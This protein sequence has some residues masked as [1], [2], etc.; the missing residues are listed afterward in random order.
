MKNLWKLFAVSAFALVPVTA[1]AA[2]TITDD[3]VCTA[4]DTNAMTECLENSATK[5]LKLTGSTY[6]FYSGKTANLEEISADATATINVYGNVTV[7]KINNADIT[8]NIEKGGKLTLTEASTVAAI[9]A[10]GKTDGATLIAK[11]LTA[12]VT[13][14]EKATATI[15]GTLTG[16]LTASKE[17]KVT[18]TATG[19]KAVF[20]DVTVNTKANVTV[21]ASKVGIAGDVTLATA[22]SDEEATLTVKASTVRNAIEGAVTTNG[23]STL[24]VTSGEVAGVITMNDKSAFNAT[25]SKVTPAATSDIKGGTMIAKEI[26]GTNLKISGVDA[27]VKYVSGSVTEANFSAGTLVTTSKNDV[28]GLDEKIV[29][30]KGVAEITI[31][32]GEVYDVKNVDT[33]GVVAITAENGAII[34][35]SGT[36][37][38]EV[39]INETKVKVAKDAKLVV[40]NGKPAEPTKPEDPDNKPTDPDKVPDVPKTGDTVLVSSALGLVSLIGLA[41]T[42]KSRKFN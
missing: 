36:A 25:S 21:N 27:V 29:T 9:T 24:N 28:T 40:N 30:T 42:V 18:V 26:V 14:T 20:G 37:D 4:A 35:N 2:V 11:D 31:A 8:V 16:D 15:T 7:K 32:N 19:D 38:K 1:N 10:D 34:R 23:K 39:V 5:S 3:G 12:T 22:A 41:A 13:A 6:T 17:A 33:T